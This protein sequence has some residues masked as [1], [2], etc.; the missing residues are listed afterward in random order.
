[1]VAIALWLVLLASISPLMWA[2]PAFAQDCTQCNDRSDCDADCLDPNGAPDKCRNHICMPP[3]P[4]SCSVVCQGRQDCDLSCVSAGGQGTF[5]REENPLTC[6]GECRDVCIT[7]GASCSTPCFARA[8]VTCEV[9]DSTCTP[10]GDCSLVCASRPVC[11]TP[12]QSSKIDTTCKIGQP[13]NCQPDNPILL[14]PAQNT[15]RTGEGTTFPPPKRQ[16]IIFESGDIAV[17]SAMSDGT[18]AIVIDNYMTINKVNVCI[19]A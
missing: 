17:I 3:P 18:G 11:S 4:N 10:A 1:M 2:V 19:G 13:N 8:T 15:F 6:V 7:T 12:C 14:F 16:P 9:F 5:C